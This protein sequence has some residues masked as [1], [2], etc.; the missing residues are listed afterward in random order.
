MTCDEAQE[1]I[2]ASVDGE[3]LDSERSSLE[4]HLV[5]CVG[6]RQ[7]LEKE[8]ALKQAIRGY[9]ERIHAPGE[10]R[11]R[12]VADRRIFPEQKP[13]P[14]GWLDYV[15]TLPLPVGAAVAMVLLLAIA[16]PTFVIKSDSEPI[17]VAAL[18]TYDRFVKGQLPVRRTDN[19][20]EIVEQLTRTVGGHFHPMGYDLTAM[21]L[22]PVAGLVREI[23]GRKVLVVIYQGPGG[24]LFCYTFIGS[25]TD[26]PPN[27]ARFFDAQ[28]KINL[29]AFS[30]GKV[31]AVFH[32]E[33][34]VICIL[35]SEM[36]MKELLALAQSKAKPS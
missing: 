1:L 13:S 25:E 27:A 24:A 21:G 6:C 8:R 23:D 35:A 2:T 10:L 11:R 28:K 29:Y 30:R 14:R 22:W 31:N 3:L 26:A 7:S 32:R 4:T 34:E 36:P 5:E 19:A 33:G 18:E 17:A 20:N 12:I 15:R 16:L 9:R